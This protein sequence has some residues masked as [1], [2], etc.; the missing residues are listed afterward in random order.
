MRILVADE[1][2]NSRYTIME[3]LAETKLELLSAAKGEEAWERVRANDP[4]RLVIL[5]WSLPELDGLDICQ[6]IRQANARDYTYVILLSPQNGKT[7]HHGSLSKAHTPANG[8]SQK[9]LEHEK[10]AL[11][12]AFEAGVDDYVTRPV[13]RDEIVARIRVAQRFLHKE[14]RL[15]QINHEWRTMIDN[16][17]FGLACLGREGEVRRV[18]RIF[19]EQ[20]GLD[21]RRIIGKSLRPGVLHRLLDYRQLFEHMRRAQQFNSLEMEMMHQDGKPRR[22]I[23]W[24]RPVDSAGELAFQIITAVQP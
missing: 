8:K 9:S 6:K 15:S 21:L 11:L 14:D 13:A 7:P 22:V 12:T 16:L 18:N 10:S 5:S 23:V 1:D 19:A 17:P 4:P 3:A 24:G 20:L 2:V